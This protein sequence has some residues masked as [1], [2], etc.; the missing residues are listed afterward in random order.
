MN[1]EENERYWMPGAIV[2]HD[3]DAK[4]ERMLM[5]VLASTTNSIGFTMIK[6]EYLDKSVSKISFWN[7][8]K[9]LHDP[10]RFGITVP[11]E[12]PA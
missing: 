1:Y 4:N 10:K 9:Y 11:K 2:I 5:R 7:E 8:K 3:G 12:K 6:T